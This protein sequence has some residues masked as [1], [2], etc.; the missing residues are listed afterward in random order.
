M[1]LPDA[2]WLRCVFQ[3]YRLGKPLRIGEFHGLKGAMPQANADRTVA[4][5]D[6]CRAKIPITPSFGHARTT[7]GDCSTPTP[8]IERP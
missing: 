4:A 6:G 5:V 3:G 2:A 7:S 1:G 8:A